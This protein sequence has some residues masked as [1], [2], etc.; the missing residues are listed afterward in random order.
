MNAVS[1]KILTSKDVY[2]DEEII[3]EKSGEDD[4][5]RFDNIS[6]LIGY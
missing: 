1:N 3:T 2:I 6:K 4:K 5:T